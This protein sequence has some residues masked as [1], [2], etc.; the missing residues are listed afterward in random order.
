MKMGI[1]LG[2]SIVA[3]LALADTMDIV[4]QVSE[5]SYFHYLNDSLYTHNGDSRGISGAQ[6]DLARENI[7]DEFT[8]LGLSARRDPFIYNSA[9]YYNVIGVKIGTTRPDD[10]YLVGAHYDSVGNPGA[11]DNASGMA[12][13]LEAARSLASYSFEATLIFAAFDREEQGLKGSWAYASAHTN[14]HILGMLSL[15][16]IAFNYSGQNQA[17]IYGSSASDPIKSNLA[18]AI[19]T[20]GADLTVTVNGALNASDH[21]PFEYYGFDAALLIEEHSHNPYYHQLGDSVDTSNYIDYAY[22]TKMTRS[23]VGFLA[24][25]AGLVI[26]EPGSASLICALLLCLAPF[27]RPKR[28]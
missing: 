15:D 14:D 1:L 2:L 6:H 25:E 28:R 24:D 11:D 23:A 26:P 5:I 16:M 13:V 27:Y 12:G 19:T 7:Y 20:Y 17:L 4:N 21:Y 18:Q 9:T 8:T 22:A 10:I 3:P